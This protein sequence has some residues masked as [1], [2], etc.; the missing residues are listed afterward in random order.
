[1][2][3]EVS[4]AVISNPIVLTT[5][6]T[7]SSATGFYRIHR[8]EAYVALAGRENFRNL[9]KWVDWILRVG[10]AHHPSVRSHQTY[11]CSTRT[12]PANCSVVEGSSG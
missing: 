10:S 2:F 3:K 6:L 7:H 8:N 9:E 5:V 1:M 12:F 11:G 4:H